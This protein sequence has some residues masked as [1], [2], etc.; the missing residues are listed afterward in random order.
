MKT[1]LPI[2]PVYANKILTGTKKVEFRKKF[3][4]SSNFVMFATSPVEKAVG[5]FTARSFVVAE[6]EFLWERFSDCGGISFEDFN[7][8]FNG[9]RRGVAYLI[10]EVTPY[11]TLRPLSYYGLSEQP[12]GYVDVVA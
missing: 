12:S 7:A 3:T 2:Y 11:D 5:E 8:Y 1:L 4:P 9:V 10:D 6:P